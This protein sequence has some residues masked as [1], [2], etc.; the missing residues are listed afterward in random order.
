MRYLWSAFAALVTVGAVA[1]GQQLEAAETANYAYIGTYTRDAPGGDSGQAFD[2]R[3]LHGVMPSS[4]AQYASMPCL[5]GLLTSATLR[6]P[7]CGA[8]G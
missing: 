8:V 7:A 4:H 3:S 5:V 6:F 1:G 2:V